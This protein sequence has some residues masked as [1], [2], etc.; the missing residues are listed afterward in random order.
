MPPTAA[1]STV[2]TGKG[3]DAGPGV[4]VLD[5]LSFSGL[6]LCSSVA[7]RATS[8]S[9]LSALEASDRPGNSLAVVGVTGFEELVV[10]DD[11]RMGEAGP[12]APA[13]M[14]STGDCSVMS[15]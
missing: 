2:G 4:L 1:P 5:S 14:G 10:E 11:V 12:V 13:G 15:G 8:A 6:F 7:S 3:L 9:S